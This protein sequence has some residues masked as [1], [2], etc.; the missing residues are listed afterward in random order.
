MVP[1]VGDRVDVTHDEDD[2]PLSAMT[3]PVT[4]PV[5]FG[6]TWIDSPEER[7]VPRSD[8][9]APQM[10]RD[11]GSTVFDMTEADTDSDD[12]LEFN[13]VD[14]DE[15]LS[16]TLIDALQDD[17]EYNVA[18]TEPVEAEDSSSFFRHDT[19]IDA[20]VDEQ[21]WSVESRT[22]SVSRARAGAV[23]L[24]RIAGFA[25]RGVKR[26]RVVPSVSQATTVPAVEE[27]SRSESHIHRRD[28]AVP[29]PLLA[30]DALFG[31]RCEGT[32]IHQLVIGSSV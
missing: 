14:I 26:L 18:S 9:S 19:Q 20:T 11:G 21:S 5:S 32:A 2:I 27:G 30:Q 23:H 13:P 3:I 15:E 1:R 8:W 28:E 17:L 31:E 4:Q 6:P 25:H 7:I 24:G 10:I 29:S 12:G 16:D 22:V